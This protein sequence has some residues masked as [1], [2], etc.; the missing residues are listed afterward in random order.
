MSKILIYGMGNVG[1]NLL[2]VLVTKGYSD[3]GIC[4]RNEDKITAL[5]LDF[6]P[7]EINLHNANNVDLSSYETLFLTVGSVYKSDRKTFLI[8]SK[9]M[10]D[11]ILEDITKRGFKGN[12]IIISNP[13][14]VLCS[15]ISIKYKNQFK[16]IISTGTIIDSMRLK[17]ITKK[18]VTLFG[19]HGKGAVNYYDV[20]IKDEELK[21][22]LS[23]GYDI[24]DLGINSSYGIAL[25]ALRLFEILKA[26]ECT[27]VAC[28]YNE[29]LGISFSHLLR[30]KNGIVESIGLNEEYKNYPLLID[31]IQIIKE[32]LEALRI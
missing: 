22:A 8:D 26:D 16:N 12:L 28:F 15:Y 9:K 14:D 31:S 23:I 24:S 4:D 20:E 18:D 10:I 3:I 27:F 25:A 7:Y 11:S 1:K 30:I 5:L 17:S 29:K 21:K 13:T 19:P 32:E 2:S 6:L